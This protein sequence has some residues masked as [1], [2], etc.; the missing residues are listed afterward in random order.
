MVRLRAPP[1]DFPRP[2]DG[3]AMTRVSGKG[4]GA[5][6]ADD[7]SPVM[8]RGAS[9]SQVSPRQWCMSG[10]ARGPSPKRDGHRVNLKK[11]FHQPLE[12][13]HGDSPYRMVRPLSPRVALV[14]DHGL[15]L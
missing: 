6:K 11:K 4:D 15:C 12:E 5:R 7:D 3:R 10:R 14:C 13:D 2:R 8:A 1:P 9:P